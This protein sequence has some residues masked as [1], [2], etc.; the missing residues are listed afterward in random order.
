MEV[1]EEGLEQYLED[2]QE[3]YEK[4]DKKLEEQLQEIELQWIKVME[5]GR[6][7]VDRDPD[8]M[9]SL[10]EMKEEIVDEE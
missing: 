9:L 1:N 7:A 4:K 8:E 6:K 3:Y 5:R 10:E 2:K